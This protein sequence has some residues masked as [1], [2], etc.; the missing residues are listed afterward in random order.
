MPKD[1]KNP[2]SKLSQKRDEKLKGQ[3]DGV[4]PTKK[5]VFEKIKQSQQKM[6]DSLQGA[7]DTSPDD[8]DIRKDLAEVVGRVAKL[9]KELKKLMEDDE[10]D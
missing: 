8:L 2:L 9:D 10:N 3:L 1:K 4:V 7:W 6:L 5:E